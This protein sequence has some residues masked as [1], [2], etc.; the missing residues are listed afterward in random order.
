MI[1]GWFI[2]VSDIKN[3]TETNKRRAEE[4][5]PLLIRKLNK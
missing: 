2:T 5:L 1:F 4:L 3:W